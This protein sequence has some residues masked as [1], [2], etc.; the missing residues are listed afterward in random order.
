VVDA[1]PDLVMHQL[2][3]LPD[4]ADQLPELGRRNIRIR[5]EGTDTL[6]AAMRAAA[7]RRILAQSIAWTPG[8]AAAAAT[9]HLE[10]AVLA[11]DG[12]VLRYGQLYGPDTYFPDPDH[13]PDD[14][15]V[16]LD[17]A[18]TLTLEHLDAPSGVYTVVD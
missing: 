2:T 3:D 13:L 5:T 11:V 14:P 16:A 17:R 10:A 7:T 4:D 18:A 9:E 12:V 8:P 15:R 1:A 6:L